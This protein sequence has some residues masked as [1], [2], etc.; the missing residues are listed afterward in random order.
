[1]ASLPNL[2]PGRNEVVES[3]GA[4]NRTVSASSNSASNPIYTETFEDSVPACLFSSDILYL[5]SSPS[6]CAAY[7]GLFYPGLRF[8]RG[9]P[10]LSQISTLPLLTSALHRPADRRLP[11]EEWWY[12]NCR[13]GLS[14][15]RQPPSDPSA[16]GISWRRS[17]T[18]SGRTGR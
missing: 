12:S 3:K 11:C 6:V 14:D 1:M 5:L 13:K 8:C 16:D 7:R 17:R 9:P 10:L 2:V 18:A 15:S 4:P